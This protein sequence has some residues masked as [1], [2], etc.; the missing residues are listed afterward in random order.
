[1][2]GAV[3]L[4]VSAHDGGSTVRWSQD[5]GLARL[6]RVGSWAAGAVAPLLYRPLLKRLLRHG[7]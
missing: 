6:G 4:T 5:L 7:G 1:M 2:L 3:D